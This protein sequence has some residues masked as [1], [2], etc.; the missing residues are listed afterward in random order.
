MSH[1]CHAERCAEK[2]KPELFMCRRHWFMVPRMLRDRIW[3]T[4][5]K[6]QC[7]DKNPSR[8]Y[9]EAA[10]AARAAVAKEEGIQIHRTYVESFFPQ[11]EKSITPSKGESK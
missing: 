10:D 9:C 5:R 6:G 7:G 2:V 1:H 11:T 4:Y 3:D 8:E